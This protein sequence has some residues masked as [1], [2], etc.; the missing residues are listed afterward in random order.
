MASTHPEIE[1]IFKGLCRRFNRARVTAE[2]SYYFSLGEDEKWTVDITR[3]KCTVTRGRNEDSDVFFKG[4]PELFLDVWNGRHQLGPKDFLTGRVKSN[5][6]LLL[7]DF[8]AVFQP[9]E[10][11]EKPEKRKK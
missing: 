5:R 11:P 2:R 8:V 4:P 1:R 3:E 6:P 10:K 9:S 7:K